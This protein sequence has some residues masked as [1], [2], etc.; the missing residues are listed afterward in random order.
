[1]LNV[2]RYVTRSFEY[3]I[4]NDLSNSFHVFLSLLDFTP[5]QKLHFFFLHLSITQP[6]DK[7]SSSE[8]SL[9]S[10]HSAE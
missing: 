4:V 8:I 2:T 7:K 10:D 5:F 1:M 3:A 6:C 9:L